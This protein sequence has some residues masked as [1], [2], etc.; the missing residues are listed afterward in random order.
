MP[1][2]LEELPNTRVLYKDGPTFK[3]RT[4]KEFTVPRPSV[5]L[6]KSQNLIVK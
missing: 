2:T 6:P 5:K 4:D 1:R 3:Q